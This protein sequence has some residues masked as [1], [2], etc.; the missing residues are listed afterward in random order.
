MVIPSGLGTTVLNTENRIGIFGGSFNPPH[1]GH[2]IVAQYAVELLNLQRLYI[3]PT[4]IPPHKQ[5]DLAPYDLRFEWCKIIFEEQRIIVSD[6][7]KTR[8]DISYSFY[9][10]LHFSQIH[11]TKP[12]FITGEDTLSYIEKWYNYEELLKICH[13]VVYP[14]YCNRP[15]EMHA[16]KVLKEFYEQIIFLQAPLI[17]L[18][19]TEIRNRVRERKS[20]KGMVDSRIEKKVIEYYQL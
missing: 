15:H 17:Q 4:Y 9:T 14:R 7:E 11:N 18:S 12:Y 6:Y 10:V 19:S 8:Q 16:K 5:N 3:V 2:L 20:I 13:F 1:I